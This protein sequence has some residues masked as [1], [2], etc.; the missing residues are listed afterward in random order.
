[1]WYYHTTIW[2]LK[3]NSQASIGN[4]YVFV[5]P[6]ARVSF[7]EKLGKKGYLW[8]FD[9]W[10]QVLTGKTCDTNKPLYEIWSLTHMHQ[11]AIYMF[12][13]PCVRVFFPKKTQK[14]WVN[15]VILMREAKSSQA[16]HVILPHPNMQIKPW[17]TGINFS[18]L[19]FCLTMCKHYLPY[20]ISLTGYWVR[21]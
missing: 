8:N 15:C 11:L 17:F 6:F 20:N 21:H 3:L 12:F 4:I 19:C 10:S 5:S 13:S 1:M 14:K 9:A 2:K 7:V 18:Y 16:K